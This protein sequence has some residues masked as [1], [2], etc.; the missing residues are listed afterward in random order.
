MRSDDVPVIL[1][2]T[3]FFQ[4]FDVCFSR[5]SNAI[6]VRLSNEAL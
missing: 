3:N 6:S 1:G 4:R 2:N 5:S